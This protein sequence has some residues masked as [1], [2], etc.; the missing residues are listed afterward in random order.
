MISATIRKPSA[1]TKPDVAIPFAPWF[2]VL[3]EVAA[4]EVPV[5]VPVEE[6]VSVEEEFEHVILDGMVK[7]LESV[8]SEHWVE[9]AYFQCD[10]ETED[11][12]GAQE[13]TW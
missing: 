7:L 3:V 4:V 13:L 1:L 8:R 11:M 10:V 9:K 5:E 12:E 6:E 2:P